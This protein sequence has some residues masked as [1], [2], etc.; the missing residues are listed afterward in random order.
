MNSLK[1]L[2]EVNLEFMLIAIVPTF[3]VIQNQNEISI[4][5]DC[6]PHVACRWVLEI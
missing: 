2:V 4:Y 1:R 6:R 5:V 3:D